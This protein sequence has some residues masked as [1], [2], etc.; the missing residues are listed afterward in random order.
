MLMRHKVWAHQGLIALLLLIV[1]SGV[2]WAAVSAAPLVQE[3]QPVQHVVQAGETLFRIAE[4]YNTTVEVIIAANGITDPNLISVGQTLIIPSQVGESITDQEATPEEERTHLTTYFVLPDDTLGSVARRFDTTPEAIAELNGLVNPTDLTAGGQLTVPGQY[5]GRVHSVVDGETA[6]GLA[7]R[8]NVPLWEFLGANGL[9]S[10]GALVPGQR[11]WVPSETTTRTLPLPFTALVIG[12][13][14][15]LQGSTVRV[16]VDLIP[17]ARLHGVIADEVLNF[18]PDG[19]SYFAL[20]GIH[21]LADPG[22]YPLALL[23]SDENGDEVYLTRSVE[24]LDGGFVTEEISLSF[25]LLDNEA[26]AVERERIAGIKPVFN[27]E[28]YWESLFTR[29]ITTEVTSDFGTRRLYKYPSTQ[30]YGYHEGT[31]FNGGIGSPVHAPAAGVVV[32]AEPLYLRGNAL[33]IDHGWGVYTGYW[34]LSQIDVAVG[35]RVEPGDQIGLVGS[36]GRSTGAHLHWDLWVNGTNVSALQW[37]E[38]VF[39]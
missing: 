25:D 29:P 2:P 39:P 7:L 13:E 23:A 10:S 38:Q 22:A 15:I 11:V 21:A 35:Q 26:I 3:E 27:P 31:D 18:A 17:G 5:V 8:H 30:F 34:H 14:P 20:F 12:P 9:S 36:T 19:G 37:T 4:R 1:L 16:K 6:Q 33:V 32:L 24:V 28:R